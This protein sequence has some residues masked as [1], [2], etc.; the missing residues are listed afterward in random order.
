M[1]SATDIARLKVTMDD[2]EPV[3]MRRLEVP[4]GLRLDRLHQVLQIAIG[5]TNSHLWEFRARDI[6][7]GF[8][9]PDW[10]DG[11]LD[12]RKVTLL[13]VLE[14]ERGTSDG[15]GTHRPANGAKTLRYLYD[16]GDGW[17]HVIKVERIDAPEPDVLYPRLLAAKGRCPPEDIGGPWGYADFLEAI[18]DPE[19]DRYEELTEWYPEDF[20]PTLVEANWI[21]KELNKLAKRWS[22]KPVKR[23]KK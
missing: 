20:D 13:N 11:P 2:V 23:K 7:W 18:A 10:P 17:E 4:L 12:A 21:E 14:G 15:M 9:D 8:P 5:W 22:R 6:G 16:F 3:V 1:I 19:H